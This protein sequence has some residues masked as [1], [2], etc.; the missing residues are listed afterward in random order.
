M[1]KKFFVLEDLT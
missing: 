1:V